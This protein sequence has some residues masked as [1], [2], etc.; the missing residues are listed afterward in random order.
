MRQSKKEQ[1]TSAVSAA[2]SAQRPDRSRR[3]VVQSLAVGGVVAGANSPEKWA[4]PVVDAI[5]L[6]GHAQATGCAIQ[7]VQVTV[8]QSADDA[9]SGANTFQQT[10]NSSGTYNVACDSPQGQ[11]PIN[12]DVTVQ[13]PGAPDGT[14]PFE[15]DYD[16]DID[17]DPRI[18]NQTANVSGG[19]VNFDFDTE[20]DEYNDP[21]VASFVIHP[22]EGCGP[23]ATIEITFPG[24]ACE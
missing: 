24:E 8:N 22:P 2:S 1:A 10:F 18:L 15:L 20:G 5:L 3:R 4:K 16:A 11:A 17:I 12:F 7:N 6:P 23:T 13:V 21:G 14:G 19:Q 9:D